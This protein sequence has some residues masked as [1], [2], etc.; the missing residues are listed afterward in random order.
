DE[1][2]DKTFEE[3][4]LSRLERYSD[5]TVDDIDSKVGSGLNKNAKN[6]CQKLALRMLGLKKNKIEEFKKGDITIKT[7]R[8]GK[9]GSPKESMSFPT[10]KYKEIVKEPWDDSKLHEMFNKKYFFIIFQYDEQKTLRFKKG[11]FWTMSAEDLKEA[12]IVW[13]KT[14]RCINAD[15]TDISEL[16]KSS[17]NRVAHVRSHGRNKKDTYETPSGRHLTKT[18]FWLNAGYIKEQIGK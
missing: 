13:N 18:C 1:L 7:I 4:I 15:I 8:L 16:P 2:K 17:E 14:R 10:F 9:N 12:K 11:M 3:I 5:M 6:Y